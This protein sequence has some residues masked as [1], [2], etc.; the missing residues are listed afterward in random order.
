[1]AAAQ[2]RL[3][4]CLWVGGLKPTLAAMSESSHFPLGKVKKRSLLT[5]PHDLAVGV[6]QSSSTSFASLAVLS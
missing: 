1:M 5:W 6:P 4:M 2:P 3:W